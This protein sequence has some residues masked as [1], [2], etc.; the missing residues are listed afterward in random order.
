MSILTI[1]CHNI[2]N[3][4]KQ[5]FDV[6]IENKKKYGEVRTDYNLINKIFKLLPQHLFENPNLKWFDPCC[7]NGYFMIV[8]FYKL[9]ISL[10]VKISNSKLRKLHIIKNML[11]MNEINIEH[12][13]TLKEIFGEHGNIYNYD[14]L[15]MSYM[16]VDIIVDNPPFNY[17]IIKT[18]TNTYISKKLDGKSIWQK[19]IRKFIHQLD[20]YQHLLTIIPSLWM[21]KDHKFHDFL[22]QFEILKLHTMNNTETNQIFHKQAQTPT[23]YFYLR[24]KPTSEYINLY[25]KDYKNYVHFP[26]NSNLPVCCSS[27]VKKLLPFTK[28]YGII[29]ILKTNLD[30]GLRSKKTF[31]SNNETNIF[32]YKNVKTCYFK[33]NTMSLNIVYT[34]KPCNFYGMEKLIFAN[35]M[36]GLP[37]YDVKGKYGIT[38][39]DNY[40]I[41]NKSHTQFLKLQKLFYTKTIIYILDSTRYRMKNLDINAFYYIPNIID[42]IDYKDINDEFLFNFF[43]F[44]SKQ[45]N[46]INNYYNS[47]DVSSSLL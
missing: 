42:S 6:N 24:K 18:H 2:F 47:V 46:I 39:K 15:K 14:Y 13:K 12:I 32:K 29:D 36:Y 25:D 35:K 7:G 38:T 17:G 33:K 11:F 1:D 19:F 26:I 27:I 4:Y 5:N 37:Q 30:P 44:D 31:V 34:N 40:V 10:Q 45:I 28:K 21:K 20:D 9:Y 23:C 8:L 16:K 22:I 43:N 41:I 3:V